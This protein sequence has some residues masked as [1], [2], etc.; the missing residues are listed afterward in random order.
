M[1]YS[2]DGAI[3]GDWEA[4]VPARIVSLPSTEGL[5]TIFVQF[6]DAAGNTSLPIAASIV[7][8]RTTPTL[9]LSEPITDTLAPYQA[10]FAWRIDDVGISGHEQ[11]QV[12]CKL[13]G[14][15]ADWRV[16][17]DSLAI[18]YS[19]LLTGEYTFRV[20]VTDQ[21]GNVQTVEKTA[22]VAP[23]PGHVYLPLVQQ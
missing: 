23:P 10:A 21:A 22:L 5:S 3:Y 15:D 18:T 2:S 6:R 11:L 13:V 16:P 9:L 4:F 17:S 7:I 19:G 8:D 12:E 1:R 14:V 20:R